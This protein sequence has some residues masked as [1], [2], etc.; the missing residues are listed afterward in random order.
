MS[1]PLNHVAS[2]G[3][4]ASSL[5]S[6]PVPLPPNHM[7]APPVSRI[8]DPSQSQLPENN[9]SL[10]NHNMTT[11]RR[12]DRP[13]VYA[14]KS[15]L[16]RFTDSTTH[17]QTSVKRHVFGVPEHSEVHHS[18]TSEM[19]SETEDDEDS[20][21]FGS[22]CGN[23]D[24]EEFGEDQ[25][26]HHSNT[27]FDGPDEDAAKGHD[28]IHDSTNF[29]AVNNDVRESNAERHTPHEQSQSPSHQ[30][31]PILGKILVCTCFMCSE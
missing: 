4:H 30:M 14:S 23:G 27:D 8:I 10:A 6:Q 31:S 21:G 17:T 28:D 5:P 1:V 16:L 13:E 25:A 22:A 24:D 18:D 20:M 3:S 19:E 15:A 26:S 11:H 2:S 7:S 9:A 29:N 12:V